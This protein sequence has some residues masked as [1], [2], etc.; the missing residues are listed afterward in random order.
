M[1]IHA[2]KMLSTGVSRVKQNKTVLKVV[3]GASVALAS[4]SSFAIDHTAVI[5]AAG[6]D[7]AANTT[8][9][10]T[11]VIAIAAVVTGITLIIGLLRK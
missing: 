6:T 1:S 8:A 2:K 3:G 9:A 7:G 4:A 11:V 5:E 10:A